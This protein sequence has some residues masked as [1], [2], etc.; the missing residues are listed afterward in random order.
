MSK[1]IVTAF[2]C[3]LALILC[4]EPLAA[5]AEDTRIKFIERAESEFLILGAKIN[6]YE[7]E[8]GM[9]AYLPE[10]KSHEHVLVPLG[11]ICAALS[12]SIMVNPGEGEA[13]GWFS[14]EK[15]TF[16]LNIPN[17]SVYVKSKKLPLEPGAAELHVDDIYVTASKMEEWFG[18][19]VS[20][21]MNALLLVIESEHELPFEDKIRRLKNAKTLSGQKSEPEDLFKDAFFIPYEMAS[22]PSFVIGDTVTASRNATGTTV[23]NLFNLQTNMD[24]MKME[25]S[26]NLSHKYDS[27]GPDEITSARLTFKR[28]DPARE[29]LGP[30]N[31]GKIEAGDISFPSVPLLVGTQSGAGILVSSDPELGFK[32]A[33]NSEDYVLEG[34][35]PVGWDAELY[36]NG[37]YSGFQQIGDDGR[38]LFE[39]LDLTGGYNLFTIVLYGPEGQKKTI[40]RE[41]YQG[42]TMLNDDELTYDVAV[43]LPESDFLPI[44]ENSESNSNVGASGQVYYGVSDFL[45]VG[46][47]VYTGPQEDE[48]TTGATLSAVTSVLG[49]NFQTQVMAAND[50]RRAYEFAARARPL[51]FNMSFSHIRYQNFEEDDQEISQEDTASISRNIG[52]VSVSF[53][54]KKKD[55]V[56]REDEIE[57]ENNVSATVLG[58]K[59]TNKLTKTYNKSRSRDDFDGELSILKTVAD[60]RF[61]GSLN[62]DLAPDAQD[63]LRL[64]SLSAQ[65]NF[66]D[67]SSLRVNSSY[68]FDAEITAG[69]F[70]YTRDFGAFSLDFTGSADTEDNYTAGIGVRTALQPSGTRGKYG[71]IE[72]DKGSQA[73][74]GIRPYLDK[75]DNSKY[76]PDFDETVQD[77]E[78]SASTGNAKATTDEEGIAWLH[79]MVETPTRIA[80]NNET[81]SSIYMMPKQQKYTVIPRQGSNA[82]IDFPFK[83]LGEIDGFVTD[84]SPDRNPLSSIPVR[85]IDMQTQKQV[86]EMESEHDGYYVFSALPLGKYKILASG[87][88]FEENASDTASRIVELTH[89]EPSVIDANLELTQNAEET[90]SLDEAPVE[91]L[92]E[93]EPV[94]PEPA[95]P[96]PVLPAVPVAP[97]TEIESLEPKPLKPEDMQLENIQPEAGSAEQEKPVEKTS[98]DEA[99]IHI[100]SLESESQAA[101]EWARMKTRHAGLIGRYEKRTEEKLIKGKKYVRLYAGPMNATES[102]QICAALI[103]AKTPG[104]CVALKASQIE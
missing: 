37:H 23:N 72:P 12:Y 96:G 78:F 83:M 35:A 26:F 101:S 46:G 21:D 27:K 70:R 89:K 53:Q 29:L 15:N 61:R 93:R 64:A 38:F 56:E 41:V 66:R 102:A 103:A 33:S 58:T 87:G 79:G 65:K 84:A 67:K 59:F 36:R 80:V 14:E 76:D 11:A 85:L 42:P 39:N 20:L 75:N 91:E 88:W 44:A 48:Q 98:T 3:S 5:R 104:G 32:Y 13:E 31:A 9:T 97:V 51:G 22:L 92:D 25:T 24:L 77:I 40:T 4:W 95:E 2:L 99:F 10:G 57:L 34:D 60:I 62:Y 54:A 94:L 30:A 45:T 43:G 1:R 82:V 63:T 73:T 86:S 17:A 55:Y 71:F 49:M 7:R 47:S 90:A 74:L 100:G 69:D 18:V 19:D 8:E 81:I 6:G 28:R 16:Q 52:R 50:S 68:N